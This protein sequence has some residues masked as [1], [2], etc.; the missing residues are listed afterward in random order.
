M[1]GN[2]QAREEVPWWLGEQTS[3]K[4]FVKQ[5][6]RNDVLVEGEIELLMSILSELMQELLDE[7]KPV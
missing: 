7:T 2:R 3:V 6:L 1:G 4:I 5:S